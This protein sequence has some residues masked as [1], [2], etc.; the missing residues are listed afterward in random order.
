MAIHPKP[1]DSPIGRAY[2]EKQELLKR[3]TYIQQAA[4]TTFIFADN[5]PNPTTMTN[6]RRY[7][8]VAVLALAAP[9]LIFID[10][11]TH[12]PYVLPVSQRFTDP[13]I[14]FERD[15]L[16]IFQ[17]NCTKGGCHGDRGAGGYKLTSYADIV[18]KG[19]VPGNPAASKI[20]ESISWSTGENKMPRGGSL[21]ATDI[22]LIR[23]WIAT[24]ALDS[25]ACYTNNC[26]TT[27]YTYSGTIAPMMQLYCT[28]C[29][30]NSSAAGGSLADYTSVYNAAVTGRLIGDI[31]H[32]AGYNAMPQGSSQLSDCQITQVKKWVAA[33]ALN[34]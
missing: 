8:I 23:Q 32:S 3:C 15:I 13:N 14:C 31:S 26:D 22:A 30:N 24:G 7:L 11:C 29:H 4:F 1:Q 16:P 27:Q 10:S 34:N 28:G 5:K 25:G 18:S 21:S 2:T 9:A 6:Y 33:G 12:Q 17:S 19:I 20:F